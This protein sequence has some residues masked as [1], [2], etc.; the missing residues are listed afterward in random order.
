MCVCDDLPTPIVTV[1][2][3]LVQRLVAHV[4]EHHDA[5]L[6][7]QEQG[8][9]AAWRAE[10]GA[11]LSAV[12]QVAT[13]GAN[14]QQRPPRSLCPHCGQGCAAERWRPR[15]V[16]TRLGVLRLRRT[17]YR[18]GGCGSRWSRAD[19]TLGLAPRQQT[20]AAV[21]AW[22]ARL[23]AVTTFREAAQLLEELAGVAV[24]AETLRTHAEQQGAALEAQ[25][26]A[27]MTH[28]AAEHEPL[29][30]TAEP[31]PGQLVA[32]SDGVFVRYRCPPSC[33]VGGWHEVKLGI[34]G[35]WVGQRP[36]ATL[37][38]PSYVGARAE[39]DAFAPRLVAEAARRGALDVVGW[40][41]PS[42]V[43][44]R[45]SGPSGPAVAVLRPTIVLGDGA[46]WIWQSVA[47]V[48]GTERTEI[49]DWF[50]AS[51]HLWDLAKALH[52]ER[53]PTTTAWAEQAHR[54]LWEQGA[55]GLLPW[56]RTTTAPT[57]DSAETLE[58]ERGFFIRHA[59]RM[60]YPTFRQQGLPIGSGAV[61]S[62]AKTLVQQRLKRAGMRWSEAGAHAIL[63]LRCRGLTDAARVA[64][65]HRPH[66]RHA[67]AA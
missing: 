30:D 53:T 3:R 56:L 65:P 42:G 10:A 15:Q 64:P 43:D 61:E 4:R 63:Q 57:P 60:A 18:C 34:V 17:V 39:V 49:V 51:A 2:H 55:D 21:Q 66:A 7:A 23:A 67:K 44:P 6:A 31:T 25:H 48:L 28:V 24:G 47:P 16:Q 13:T 14:P 40:V 12:V 52:G 22:E 27:Q 54:L 46:A 1:V 5:D 26:Q 11:L 37:Q 29:P 38:R 58:R 9:L 36:D 35:G 32:Q 45:L 8:L 41:Q 33:C 50:H 62:A 59:A 19:Q 20:S